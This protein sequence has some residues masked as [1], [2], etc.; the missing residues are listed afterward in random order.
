MIHELTFIYQPNLYKF[1]MLAQEQSFP[2][3]LGSAFAVL[4]NYLTTTDK[5]ALSST[6]SLLRQVLMRGPIWRIFEITDQNIPQWGSF[7]CW[8]EKYLPVI[9]PTE[10]AVT[11]LEEEH[12][13]DKQLL[14]ALLQPKEYVKTVSIRSKNQ[15]IHLAIANA[16]PNANRITLHST[17]V[18]DELVECMF[19]HMNQVSQVEI[20]SDSL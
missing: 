3:D 11:V 4:C 12:E 9:Q 10:L 17:E 8:V 2:F 16:C 1:D 5:V 15:L 20:A 7:L 14:R 6:C 13:E 18:T 19:K